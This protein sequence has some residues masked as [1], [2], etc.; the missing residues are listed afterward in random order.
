MPSHPAASHK[1]VPACI[2]HV[3]AA[4]AVLRPRQGAS[5]ETR[6]ANFVAQAPNTP[7]PMPDNAGI[8]AEEY[9]NTHL[10]DI[11]R[12]PMAYAGFQKLMVRQAIAERPTPTFCEVVAATWPK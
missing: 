1:S 11:E 8:S 3:A 7:S 4:N 5:T 10:A 12:N 6:L 2:C 9:F